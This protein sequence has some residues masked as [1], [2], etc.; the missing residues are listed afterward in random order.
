MSEHI[1]GMMFCHNEGDI[2]AQT[3]ESAL[4]N[5]DSLFIA[6]D[7]STDNSFDIIKAMH[8]AHK[9]KIELAVHRQKNKNDKGQR[10]FLLDEIRK[11]YKPENTWV[12]LIESD[13]MILDTDIRKAIKEHAVHDLAMSWVALNA[14]RE[15]GTWKEA[16]TY[17]HWG[18]PLK[19]IM[20]GAHWLEIML[21]TWR[22]LEKLYFDREPWR[23]WPRGFSHYT[24][25]E[26]KG[27]Y[28]RKPSAPLL[29]H[30]GYRG[31]T[32]FHQKYFG[33]WPNNRHPKYQGWDVSSP[34]SCD[35]TVWF[36]N[37]FWN[38]ELFE[39]SR[40]GWSHWRRS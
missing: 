14:A 28:G 39:P 30:V 26:V 2:L 16:D 13:I 29:L 40:A 33:R 5:V 12:Q 4:D 19:E 17:P 31:P 23:P 25:Q 6:D 35:K 37:G 36:F 27:S 10:S 21:Y 8:R 15:A 9:D 20:Y 1:V 7:G 22:P 18:R 3:I 32:H 34:A 38:R 11:R 24:N